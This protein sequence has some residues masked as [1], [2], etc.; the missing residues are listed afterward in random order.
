LAGG[1]GLDQRVVIAGGGGG[2]G[3]TPNGTGMTKGVRSG[4]GEVTISW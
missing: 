2:S 4:N 1:T 3:L